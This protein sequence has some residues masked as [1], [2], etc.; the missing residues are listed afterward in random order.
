M[1]THC[2]RPLIL[3]HEPHG[4]HPCR[5]IHHAICW[6][7]FKRTPKPKA[8]GVLNVQASMLCVVLRAG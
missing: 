2:M 5:D 8:S 6:L 1:L 4:K 7:P 3:R